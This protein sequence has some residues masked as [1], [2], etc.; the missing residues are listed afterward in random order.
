M[1]AYP[2]WSGEYP[3]PIIA[4]GD[5]NNKQVTINGYASPRKLETLKKCT[6]P[7][8]VL[9]PWEAEDPVDTYYTFTTIFEYQVLENLPNFGLKKGDVLKNLAGGSENS[10]AFTLVS[11]KSVKHW[12]HTDCD[13]RSPK[14]TQETKF[15][16]HPEEQWLYLSCKEGYKVFVQ[17]SEMLKQTGINRGKTCPHY[18]GEVFR[19]ED[20]CP[21]P[22]Y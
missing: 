20:T 9:N 5:S 19:S 8:W 4:V 12:Y 3:G 13:V 14:Y 15:E 21:P 10:C 17:D 18:Y 7:A 6:I 11:G 16:S 22:P 2:A 1:L